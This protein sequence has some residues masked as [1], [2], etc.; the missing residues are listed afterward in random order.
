MI[1]DS[2]AADQS[3]A[4]RDNAGRGHAAQGN[5]GRGH[6]LD[7]PAL[8]LMTPSFIEFDD[9]MD[10]ALAQLVQRWVHTAAPNAHRPQIGRARMGH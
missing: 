10:A 3:S 8:V 5:A 6:V 2:N 9:W 1:N 7:E 4:N